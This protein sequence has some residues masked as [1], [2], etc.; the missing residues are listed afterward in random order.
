MMHEVSFILRSFTELSLFFSST[1]KSKRKT[2]NKK[3]IHEINE[4]DLIWTGINPRLSFSHYLEMFNL[5]SDSFDNEI[6]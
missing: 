6:V 5:K 4:L 1:E 2:Q 3:F